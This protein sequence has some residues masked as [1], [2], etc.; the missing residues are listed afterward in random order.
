ML[1]TIHVR[2]N[3]SKTGV[4][5]AHDGALVVRVAE[6]PDGGRATAAAL[7]AVAVAL[8]VPGRSVRLVRGATSRRKLIEIAVED[9]VGS[10]MEERVA[11]LLGPTG[12]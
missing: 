9:S 7:R 11:G 1:L 12:L 5:G 2:P 8:D 3:A 6:P 4:G 10:V